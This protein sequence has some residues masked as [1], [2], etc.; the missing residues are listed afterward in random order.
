MNLGFSWVDVFAEAQFGGNQLCVFHPAP[1][2][3]EPDLM[4]RITREM[5]HAE[6]VFVQPGTVAGGDYRIRI[7]VPVRP[8]A[9][10]IPFAGHPILGAACAMR[11]EGGNVLFETGAG[12]VPVEVRVAAPGAWE[13]R[14]RQP[15]PRFAPMQVDLTWLEAAL[16]VEPGSI[17]R[18]L[19]IERADNGMRTILIP[20]AVPAAVD[21]ARPDLQSLAKLDGGV[22]SCVLV[23]AVGEGALRTRV[24]CPFDLNP[25]DAATGSASGPLG[26]YAVRHGILPGP[27]VHSDQGHAIGRPSR[28][29][30]EIT[31][32][33]GSTE[34]VHVGGRVQYVGAGT[35]R[36]TR[37]N[38]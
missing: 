30:M 24:F 15:L 23:F 7:W 36:L 37:G 4:R 11:P 12:L 22:D 21:G 13:T 35:F 38:E 25:E 10:E 19:P 17:R 32:S 18:G 20:L 27:I 31:R 33:E 9:E 28:L 8:L 6:T 29:T 26:E 5:N 14:M 3:L 1:P 2:E 34:A 16:G